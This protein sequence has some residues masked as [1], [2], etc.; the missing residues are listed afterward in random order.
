MIGAGRVLASWPPSREFFGPL[1]KVPRP[2]PP[3]RPFV[4]SHT[5]TWTGKGYRCTTCLRRIAPQCRRPCSQEYPPSLTEAINQRRALHHSLSMGWIDGSNMPIIFC[6]LCGGY[7]MGRGTKLLQP[8]LSEQERLRQQ[9][10][11]VSLAGA[12]A[13]PRVSSELRKLQR[14]CVPGTTLTFSKV[15]F[16]GQTF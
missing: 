12:S 14:G 3:S 9:T 4:S 16:L 15:T 10:R 5:P 6:N 11:G 1:S 7:S 8:C 13:P 2:A